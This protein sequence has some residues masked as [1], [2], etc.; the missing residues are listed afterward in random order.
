MMSS[1][2]SSPARRFG[3]LG[4]LAAVLSIAGVAA[5]QTVDQPDAGTFTTPSYL[6]RNG[7]PAGPAGIGQPGSN[8][9]NA[10]PQTGARPGGPNSNPN[11]PSQR[12]GRDLGDTF[13]RRAE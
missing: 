8:A 13:P 10:L 11:G 7:A 4:V 9:G 1:I 3:A 12:N 2:C 6:Q 5:A